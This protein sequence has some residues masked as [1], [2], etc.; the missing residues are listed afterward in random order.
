MLILLD[1]LAALLAIVQVDE[2][3]SEVML[4]ISS[5]LL[6]HLVLLLYVHCLSLGLSHLRCG[7]LVRL[8]LGLSLPCARVGCVLTS[9]CE[10]CL[11]HLG[12]HLSAIVHEV[13]ILHHLL[14]S[15][16]MGD[17]LHGLS[18]EPFKVHF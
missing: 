1:I 13:L 17:I 14:V 12:L 4:E 8:V 18:L 7:Y 10:G 15:L 3:V 2:H 11:H 9:V 16:V 5:L 6:P